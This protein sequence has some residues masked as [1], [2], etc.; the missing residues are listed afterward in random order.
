MR[1]TISHGMLAIRQ[2]AKIAL[3]TV[4]LPFLLYGGM[5]FTI[6]RAAAHAARL[7]GL[8]LERR[9][10]AARAM[11]GL[12][13]TAD[14]TDLAI[15][16]SISPAHFSQDHGQ[17]ASLSDGGW[18]AAWDDDRRGSR[19]VFWQ[20]YD[21]SGNPVGANQIMAES[22]HGD[23]FVDPKLAVDTLG[24]VYLAYRNQTGG[25]LYAAR[26]SGSLEL[27]LGPFLVND[28]SLSSFAGPFDM[29]VFPDGIM[30]L[31]WENY[32]GFG[33]TIERIVYTPSGTPVSPAATVNTDGGAASHWVPAV[34]VA[35]G[36]GFLV[37]WE[38]Y[39]N[40]QADVYARRYSGDGAAVG[41]DFAL[42]PSPASGFAQYAPSV[43]W[44]RKDKFVVGWIDLRAGQEVYL[45]RFDPSVGL[46]G[47][48]TL[49]SSGQP[50]V[51]NQ[52]VDLCGAVA[53]QLQVAW[54]AS[55]AD[56]TIQSL[57]LDSGL[58]P[59]GLPLVLNLA[60]LGKRWAPATCFDADG[61]FASVWTEFRD[62]DADLACMLFDDQS[63]RLLPAEL[64]VNDDQ[65]GAPSTAPRLVPSD[66]WWNL[67]AYVDSRYD[68]GDIFTR[69]ISNGGQYG[70]AETKVNQDAG[71]N[72]QSEPDLA[73][74]DDK[75]LVVWNDSRNVGGVSGQRI[76]GRFGSLLGAYSLPEFMISDTSA[77]AVKAS[78]RAAMNAQ[79]RGLVAWVDRRLGAAQVYGRWLAANGSL[80]GAEF[81]VSIPATDLSAADLEVCL[82][83]NGR[84]N[85][86]WL[87][88]G[89]SE[90]TMKL[91]R[92]DV[93]KTPAGSFT[94]APSLGSVTI[95]Q[96]ASTIG[97]GGTITIF[98]TG[99]NNSR[100]AYL[101]QLNSSGAEV[102]APYAITDDD[103]AYPTDPSVSVCE[104]G[105]LS[106]AWRDYRDGR[107]LAYYQLLDPGGVAIDGNQPVS[108]APVE[109]TLAPVTS[110][111]RGRVWFVWS[112]PREN[113]LGVYGSTVIYLPTDVDDP[114]GGALPSGYN[115]A[116][117]YPNP[118]NPSTQMVFSL[119][120]ASDVT[121]TIYNVL[122][123]KVTTL[124]R[125]LWPAGE[126]VVT[127]DGTTSDGSRVSSGVYFYKLSANGFSRTRKMMLL[128]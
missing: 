3:L 107:P 90:P 12:L 119:P 44:S 11:A 59:A 108:T 51:V 48:N 109:F 57:R 13:A 46:I 19:K 72:L 23:D 84:F 6:D 2:I 45:Q 62:S 41:A 73:A 114:D 17:V 85:V 42:V 82:D 75:T 76:Y 64:T 128:K 69:A 74:A 43:A 111:S 86:I 81:A 36:I 39:R 7:A 56:N 92:Y 123:Q 121:L 35:P 127:W 101:A 60:T 10:V 98:W 104:N 122:G 8:D 116:Q 24:R 22:D 4:G 20:R 1:I 83:N 65:I 105:Y 115:L 34:A 87:D 47:S 88:I 66:A 91:R 124:V 99:I 54:S 53:G 30:V 120:T 68:A 113:G 28:T 93:N 32:S 25:F 102:T 117:N 27:Q 78:P 70:S 55:G 125:G 33:S 103:L 52:D 106:L 67:V 126:H 94:Y 29:A 96:M 5:A 26:Y 9:S 100:R 50:A 89:Q 14:V 31:V 97:P 18:L 61:N 15:S 112:D 110:A 49:I 79:G 118:F 77:T 16:G 40:G 37:I 58:V 71:A 95:D 63:H 80:D 38:D 21:S